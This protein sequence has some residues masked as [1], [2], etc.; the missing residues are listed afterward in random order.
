MQINNTKSQTEQFL[1]LLAVLDLPD[2]KEA[3]LSVQTQD[4]KQQVS[5]SHVKLVSYKGNKKQTVIALLKYRPAC[6]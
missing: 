4:C 1:Y 5:D 3:V 6:R 2:P